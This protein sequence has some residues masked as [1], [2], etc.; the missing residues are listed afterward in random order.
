VRAVGPGRVED[1]E[2][3]LGRQ[4]GRRVRIVHPPGHEAQHRV[5][6]TPVE[7]LEEPR[8]TDRRSGPT[9]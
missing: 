3:D 2:E 8:I 4:V 5:D 1:R 9:P 6:V 7:L